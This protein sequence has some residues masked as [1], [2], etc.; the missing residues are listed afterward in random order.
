M[1]ESRSRLHNYGDT[2]SQGSNLS[3]QQSFRRQ[4]SV[5]KQRFTDVAARLQHQI[6][7][8]KEQASND[9]LSYEKLRWT[10][11]KDIIYRRKQQV[12]LP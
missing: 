2:E 9:F 1:S 10:H 6:K 4:N 5:S 3:R 11:Y 12:L 7:R 8:E